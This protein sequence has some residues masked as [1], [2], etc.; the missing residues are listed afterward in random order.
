M[1]R[2]TFS[3]GATL[4][5][6]VQ[7]RRNSGGPQIDPDLSRPSQRS[8]HYLKVPPFRVSR[9]GG[10]GLTY[11]GTRRSAFRAPTAGVRVPAD[12]DAWLD[13]VRAVALVL[14][15]G[16]AFSHETAAQLL[17]LPLPCH[18]ARPLHVTVPPHV[19]R[20]RRRL[21]T[22][23]ATALALRPITVSGL[24]VTDG[25]TTW[26]QLG[27]RLDL[28]ELVAV[29]DCLLRRGM[30]TS[31]PT[32][33]NLR[34]ARALRVSKELAD[35]RSRSPQESILRVQIHLA[36]LPSPQV[37]FDVIDLGEWIGCGDLV[38]PEYRLY[39]EYDGQHHANPKQRHQD[40]QTRNRL[41]QLGWTVR[42]VTA[43]MMKRIH[44]VIDM[45]R[46]DL[47]TR[48]WTP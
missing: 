28:P 15:Q 22:W 25:V 41:G 4:A 8:V 45:L 21:I 1:R 17:G 39:V 32:A 2:R 42:V 10:A 34:G 33:E 44:V 19:A 7:Q 13:D 26:L 23:H 30:C 6:R 40:A 12:E 5:G 14:P 24:H 35:P 43:A 9:L 29:A 16:A 11:A 3:N 27:D 18:D 31:L 48:G 47:R 38:W 36:G 20:G 46:E 37:N